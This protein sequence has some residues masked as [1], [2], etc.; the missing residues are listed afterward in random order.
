M[1]SALIRSRQSQMRP[2]IWLAA[3][4]LTLAQGGSRLL[5]DP[6]SATEQAPAAQARQDSPEPSGATAAQAAAS[7][8][9]RPSSELGSSEPANVEELRALQ[10]KIQETA[11]KVLPTVVGV[12]VGASQ[13]SGVI[14]SEDGLILTAGHV[15]GK[16]GLDVDVQLFDGRTVKGKTLGIHGNADAGMMRITTEG[17]WYHAETAKTSKQPAGT[18]CLAVG[19]P[20]G[21]QNERPPVVRV[22]RVLRSGDG[23]VQT[24]CPLVGGDSGGPLFDLE[25]RVFGINSRIGPPIEFNYHVPIDAFHENWDRLLGSETWQDKLPSRESESMRA[26][27]RP[28]VA[29]ARRC[30]VQVLCDG[31]ETVLG[32]VV[33]P[34]GWILTKAS[35]LKGAVTCR[36][37][38]GRELPGQTVGISKEF[39]LAM[40]KIETKGLP[41]VDWS[42]DVPTVGQWVATASLGP[43]PAAIGVVSVPPRRIPPMSGMLGITLDQGESPGGAKIE[44]VVPDSPAEQ[45]GL[46][47]GDVVTHVN[48]KPVETTAALVA[49]IRENRPGDIVRLNVRRGE[50][51]LAVPVKLGTIETPGS[52]RRQAQNSSGM[53]ISRRH[54][55]FPAVVQHDSALRPNECGSPIVDLTGKV[56][57]INIA[58][59]GRTETYAAPTQELFEMMYEMMAGMLS[60]EQIAAEEAA[61]QRELAE[62]AAALKAEAEKAAAEAKAREEAAKAAADKLAAEKALAEQAAA[63]K[64]ATAEATTEKA[65]ADGSQASEETAGNGS[66]SPQPARDPKAGEGDRAESPAPDADNDAPK[67][68]T[69]KK[70]R[71]KRPRLEPAAEAE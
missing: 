6:P 52:Q 4:L 43:D 28:L 10:S 11:K 42:T 13:G 62:K 55:D 70:K 48:G 56:V 30:T 23:F 51:V 5:A 44:K 68:E 26:A 3:L 64:R 57:G 53:G 50:R 15:A 16:P 34:N 65:N 29:E 2:W 12:R 47:E 36:L 39:D 45:A 37:S 61:R 38:D 32:T 17:R 66:A 54:D 60:P 22:G 20:L 67:T 33:G 27:F 41:A 49:A 35:E 58:R 40:L 14:V 63:E 18:W 24:D 25:G 1:K 46:K 31:V 8:S 9:K 21:F 7:K 19:H 69:G 71:P 59:A